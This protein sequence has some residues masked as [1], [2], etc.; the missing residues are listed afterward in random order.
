MTYQE[1]YKDISQ[2]LSNLYG[3]DSDKIKEAV[4][5]VN[6]VCN[7]SDSSDF[8]AR[9]FMLKFIPKCDELYSSLV[10]FIGQKNMI[11]LFCYNFN[12]YISD[13]IDEDMPDF[14]NAI[15][16]N[17]VPFNWYSLS[18]NCGWDVSRW[19]CEDISEN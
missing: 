10:L 15:F 1:L 2:Y 18:N 9:D 11:E 8:D 19:E 12:R 16:D 6:Y 3:V 14:V 13:M 5:L 4:K 17:S 7:L